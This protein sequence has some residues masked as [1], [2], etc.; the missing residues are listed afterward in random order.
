MGDSFTEGT[1]ALPPYNN[2]A[3]TLVRALGGTIA[4]GGV[5][6]TGIL[7]PGSAPKVA[8]TESTRILDLTLAGVTDTSG[9]V[10]GINT[11]IVGPS[12]QGISF[13]IP[14]CVA[15][16]VYERLKSDG[17]VTRGWLGVEMDPVTEQAAQDLG[18]DSAA[19]VLVKGHVHVIERLD[20]RSGLPDTVMDSSIRTGDKLV[21][22]SPAQQA[23]LKTGD[24]IQTWNGAAVENPDSLLRLVAKT[25]VGHSV[26]VGVRREGQSLT[27]DVKLGERP[28]EMDSRK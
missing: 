19:G 15:R 20:K 5:G 1:G 6:S 9:R 14:S 27:L 25:S 2:E 21:Q 3:I 13:A 12:Y 11:A 26:S 18:L 24:V 16:E 28:A 8:W 7:N 10:I 17:H 23:G 4:L 22:R